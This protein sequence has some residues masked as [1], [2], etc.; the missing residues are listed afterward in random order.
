MRNVS[1]AGRVKPFGAFYKAGE[2]KGKGAFATAVVGINLETKDEETGYWKEGLMKIKAFGWTAERLHDSFQ[3]GDY[4]VFSG[5]LE[6]GEDYTDKEGNL[7]KGTW[8]VFADRIDNYG[9][10][11]GDNSTPAA[12]APKAPGKPT[13]KVAPK[14]PSAPAAPK[15]PKAPKMPTPKK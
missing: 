10:K 14:T 15:M 13:P 12:E 1:L 9:T 5:R 6:M 4:I 7:V 3:T 2:E 11:E 8:E